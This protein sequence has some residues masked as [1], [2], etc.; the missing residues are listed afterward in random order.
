MYP[1]G[2]ITLLERRKS[3]L[4]ARIALRRTDLVET[5]D[6]AVQ[7][8][9]KIDRWRS[10]L[11]PLRFIWPVGAAVVMARRKERQSKERPA[12]VRWLPTAFQVLRLGLRF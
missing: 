4:Q 8:L 5:W 12:W 2:Q 9:V 11:R 1:T 10:W 6:R 3:E 7:P